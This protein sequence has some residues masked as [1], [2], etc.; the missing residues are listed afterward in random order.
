MRAAVIAIAL[1]GELSAG[2]GGAEVRALRARV[3]T[4][5][6]RSPQLAKLEKRVASLEDSA[7]RMETLIATLSGNVEAATATFDKLHE[8]LDRITAGLEEVAT[9]AGQGQPKPYRPT[10]RRRPDPN[11]VYSVPVAGSPF[12]GPRDAVVT[13]VRGFEFACPYC[14]RSRATL[15]QLRRDYGKDLRI[16]YKHFIVHPQRATTPALAAC[17]AHQQKRFTDMKDAIWQRGYLAGRDLGEANMEK[18]ADDLGLRMGKF[19]RDMKGAKCSKRLR[20]DRTVLT[21]VGTSG[22]PAFYINGRFISGAR[23]IHMFKVVIDEEL[24]KARAVLKKGKLKRRNYYRE[25]VEKLGKKS[26]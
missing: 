22:T 20:D 8:A 4:L 18:I 14:E 21:K 13:I 5:E 2:C 15:K 24:K 10:P 3:E 9:K 1:L 6:A 7:R 26:L 25:K 23:P 16:V 12:E 19:R 11:E 17:A